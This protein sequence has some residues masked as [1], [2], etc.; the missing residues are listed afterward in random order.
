M[1][2]SNAMKKALGN[3]KASGPRKTARRH[4]Q[5]ADNCFMAVTINRGGFR[6]ATFEP[7]DRAAFGDVATDEELG[8]DAGSTSGGRA[9]TST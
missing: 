8:G 2:G 3:A 1:R 6:S 4:W 7:S 5:D 9:V